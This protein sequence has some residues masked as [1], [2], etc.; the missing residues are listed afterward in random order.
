MTYFTPIEAPAPCTI[1]R[2]AVLR[3][4]DEFALDPGPLKALYAAKSHADAEASVCR[5]LEEIASRLDRLHVART[6][7]QYDK[8]AEPARRVGVI[9]GGLGLTGIQQIAEDVA[10][11]AEGRSGVAV[12]ATMARLER[13]FDQA[14]S[15]IWDY[16]ADL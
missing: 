11:A 15:G 7:G 6:S 10:V 16:R 8:I 14:V 1:P 9:A 5:A 4:R 13:C 12:S 3:C 2:I